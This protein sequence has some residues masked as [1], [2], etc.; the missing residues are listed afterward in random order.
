[1]KRASRK[2]AI[3]TA[4][5]V[6][7]LVW[8][9][10]CEKENVRMS[11][12]IADENRQL[13]GQLKEKQQEIDNQKQLLNKCLEEKKGLQQQER[14]GLEGMLSQLVGGFTEE[15]RKLREENAGLRKQIEELKS[16]M[17]LQDR[18]GG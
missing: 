1:M 10:G 9:L 16:Q 12:L 5:V 6:C 4:C 7:G 18:S 15:S 14:E 8:T 13:K 17:A 2:T 3:L 11:K